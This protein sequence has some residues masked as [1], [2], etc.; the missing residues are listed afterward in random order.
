MV[1]QGASGLTKSETFKINGKKKKMA[2]MLANPAEYKNDRAI[3]HALGISHDTFYR[4]LRDD[5][6]ITQ[7]AAYLI[8]KYTDK[9]LGSV[10][11]A[12][13]RRCKA[14]DVRAIKL[15]FELKGKY[16]Q[17]VEVE[18]GGP[19]EVNINIQPVEPFVPEDET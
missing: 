18:S 4:W 5:G 12:L 16:K 1:N 7:Y 10:W 9:E 17:Q 13:I 11:A 8:E 6:E 15:Y 2:E 3:Y 14:G 19:A